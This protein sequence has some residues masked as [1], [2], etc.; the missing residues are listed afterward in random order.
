[1][2]VNY[3]FLFLSLLIQIAKTFLQDA[4]VKF[5]IEQGASRNKLVLG[6]PTY[7]RSY[8]LVTSIELWAWIRDLGLQLND[9]K[10]TTPDQSM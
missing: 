6:I 4:T 8:T 10:N 2:S 7:G 3:C 1:M 5:Y 9:N